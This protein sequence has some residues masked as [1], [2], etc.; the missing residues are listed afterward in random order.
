MLS[1]LSADM[2]YNV[3]QNSRM[4]QCLRIWMIMRWFFRNLEIKGLVGTDFRPVFQY[5]GSYGRRTKAKLY[6]WKG[7]QRKPV[8]DTAFI[9]VDDDTWGDVPTW[10]MKV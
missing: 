9:F 6:G 7:L 4:T 10:A 8:Y 5:N 1:E 3:M 2:W